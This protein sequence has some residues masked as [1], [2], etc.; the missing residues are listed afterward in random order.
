MKQGHGRS[1]FKRRPERVYRLRTKPRGERT[2]EDSGESSDIEPL[3][4]HICFKIISPSL[5]RSL[6]RN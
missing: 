5:N 1:T 2:V 4:I 3:C 6:A